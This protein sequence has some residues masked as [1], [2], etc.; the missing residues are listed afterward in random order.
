[1]NMFIWI[2]R[3]DLNDLLGIVQTTKINS[4]CFSRLQVFVTIQTNVV[5]SYDASH[6]IG[7]IN[8]GSVSLLIIRWSMIRTC[9]EQFNDNKKKNKISMN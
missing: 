6:Y 3:C 5:T 2:F 7:Y 4:P 9:N 8:E 1:M